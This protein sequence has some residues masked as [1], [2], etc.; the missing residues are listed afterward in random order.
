MKLRKRDFVAA[1]MFAIIFHFFLIISGCST[2]RQMEKQKSLIKTDCTAVEKTTT[3][4]DITSD[5]RTIVSATTETTETIDTVVSVPDPKTG[6]FIDVPVNLKKTTK[7]N[8]FKSIQESKKDQSV[9]NMEK[10]SEVNRSAIE[11]NKK[12]ITK[13]PNTVLYIIIAA[14]ILLILLFVFLWK[15]LPLTSLFSIFKRKS[16]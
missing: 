13:R 5:I 11:Q 2:S 14:A 12:V 10:K 1:L 4:F 6:I 7:R 16:P 9:Q 3:H 15:R 8:E